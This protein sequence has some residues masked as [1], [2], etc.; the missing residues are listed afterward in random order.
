[1]LLQKILLTLGVSALYI[2]Y[3]GVMGVLVRRAA[4]SQRRALD[5]IVAAMH[6]LL[7]FLPASVVILG[8]AELSLVVRLAMFVVGLSVATIGL[9]QPPWTPE[10]LWQRPS[11]YRYFAV[12]MALTAVWG[13][14]SAVMTPSL[15]PTI[16]GAAASIACAISLNLTLPD[17]S[18]PLR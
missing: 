18:S 9:I 10:K 6:G 5:I 13:L 7:L 11:G 16:L 1:M 15:S 17:A 2:G 8:L 3:A 14:G 12:A 4:H